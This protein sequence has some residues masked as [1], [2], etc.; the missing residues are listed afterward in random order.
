MVES[1]APSKCVRLKWPN[2][3]MVGGAKISGILLETMLDPDQKP[4][5]IVGVGI[6]IA[7]FPDI[8]NYE[9]TSL[10]DVIGRKI[11]L[12]WFLCSFLHII[13]KWHDIWTSKG[14]SP[15]RDAWRSRAFGLNREVHVVRDKYQSINGTFKGISDEGQIIIDLGDGK[16]EFFS[17]GVVNFFQGAGR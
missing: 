16:V 5:V 10:R 12:D 9:A 6:N 3:V 8:K 13:V 15:I 14:F 2:D 11:D 4:A 7:H 1:L 17:A